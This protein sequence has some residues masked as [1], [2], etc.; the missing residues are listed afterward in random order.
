MLGPV[1]TKQT[2]IAQ[3]SSATLGEITC[4]E[5]PLLD[6]SNSDQYLLDVL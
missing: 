6:C 2:L 4:L 5:L 1:K 3:V